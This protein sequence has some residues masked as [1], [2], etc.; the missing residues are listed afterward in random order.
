MKHTL[1]NSH[2]DALITIDTSDGLDSD[3]E[4]GVSI[5]DNRD[6]TGPKSYLTKE[7]AALLVNDLVNKFDLE[8][9][10]RFC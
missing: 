4:L 8:L 2:G 9:K 7:S 3:G 10:P 1:N 6:I 5:T